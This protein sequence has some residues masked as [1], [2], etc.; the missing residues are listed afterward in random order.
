VTVTPRLWRFTIGSHLPASWM[1]RAARQRAVNL[2]MA[3]SSAPVRRQPRWVMSAP[4]N[5]TVSR[6]VRHVGVL[7]HC[8]AV[9]CLCFIERVGCGWSPA[10]HRLRAGVMMAS[11]PDEH[12]RAA[13]CT[14]GICFLRSLPA[15]WRGPGPDMA[16]S[17]DSP[18][19]RKRPRHCSTVAARTICSCCSLPLARGPPS[20]SSRPGSSSAVSRGSSQQACG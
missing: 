4:D 6:W 3:D 16:T 18:L 12:R 5:V 14:A 19:A 7:P 2:V 13:C 1:W 20:T 8:S 17:S 9:I 10:R 11:C 15:T